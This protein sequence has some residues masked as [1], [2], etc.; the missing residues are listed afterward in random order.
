MLLLPE[1]EAYRLI[2]DLSRPQCQRLVDI[3]TAS[4]IQY[5]SDKNNTTANKLIHQ[6]LRTP[7]AT[8][9][10]DTTLFMPCSDTTNT[11]IKAITLPAKGDTIGVTLVFAPTGEMIGM[12][13]ASQ[14]TAF[15][16]ALTT[17][18]LFTRV[19]HI[20]KKHIVVFGSGKQVEWHIRLALLLAVE[21]VESVTV[22][23]RGRQRLNQLEKDLIQS[24]RTIYPR[25]TFHLIAKEDTPDYEPALQTHLA[26]ADAIFCCTPS[27]EPLFPFSLLE[28][29]SKRRFISL[30]G[31]YKPHMKEIDTETLLSGGGQIFVDSREACLEES[32]E[33]RDGKVTEEQLI[34]LGEYLVPEVS[35]TPHGNVVLKCVGMGIMDLTIGRALLQLAIDLGRGMSVEGF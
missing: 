14:V 17:M 7:I 19:T 30:I 10:N 26:A 25:V 31:S 12:L 8:K 32:G 28:T 21:E 18:C 1:Q 20:P 11:G 29:C 24:L 9:N 33:L 13:G 22:V 27:T 15:R 2:C 23:N 6:P 34:E 5:S 4:L 3:L 16:T 35:R